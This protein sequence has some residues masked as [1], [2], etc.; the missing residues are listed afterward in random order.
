MP[1]TEP[2]PAAPSGPVA[3]A[4]GPTVVLVHGAWGDPRDFDD[5]VA[6][7]AADGIGAVAVDLPTMQRPDATVLDDADA[8]RQAVAEAAAPVILCG[9]SYGGAVITQAGVEG[10]V[11][12]LVYLAAVVPDVGQSMRDVL[13]GGPPEAGPGLDVRADGTTLLTEWASPDWDYPPEALTRMGR[14]PRRPFAEG[15]PATPVTVAAWRD[16]PSTY[17]LAERDASIPAVRQREMA[18][19]CTRLVELDSGH[20]V[21]HEHPE[22]VAALLVELALAAVG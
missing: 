1:D 3:P 8:V 19:G 5:V 21:A 16:R 11:A 22:A 18:A 6:A 15:G 17:V 2:S 9:H 7:L 14:H 12:H 4:D 20:M 10:P 13:G